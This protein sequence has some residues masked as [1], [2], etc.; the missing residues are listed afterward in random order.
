MDVERAEQQRGDHDGRRLAVLPHEDAAQILMD[1]APGQEFLQDG[2]QRIGEIGPAQ[3]APIPEGRTL[4]ETPRRHP[5]KDQLY[6]EQQGRKDRRHQDIHLD[7]LTDALD[8]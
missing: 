7:G 5:Q 4:R 2:R 3:L 8:L 6:A 1:D